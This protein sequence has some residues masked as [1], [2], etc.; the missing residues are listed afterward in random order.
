MSTT[1]RQQT[2]TTHGEKTCA[3]HE[4]YF[5]PHGWP[6]HVELGHIQDAFRLL[7]AQIGGFDQYAEDQG[8]DA[9]RLRAIADVARTFIDLAEAL[10]VDAEGPRAI[11]GSACRLQ[12]AAVAPATAPAN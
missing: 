4:H 10:A 2:T 6:V 12:I 8:D 1:T 5:D 9:P 3:T 11:D 7:G